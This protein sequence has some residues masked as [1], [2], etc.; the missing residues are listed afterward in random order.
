MAIEGFTVYSSEEAQLYNRYRWWLGLTWGDVLDKVSDLYPRKVGLVDDDGRLTY[1]ELRQKVDCLALGLMDLGIKPTDR[2]LLQVPNWCEYVWAF[3][4][5]QKIGA[6]PILLLPRHRETEINFLSQL[7]QA[8]AW[9]LP[10]KN[11][12]VDYRPIIQN[13]ARETPTIENIITVR[14]ERCSGFL[15]ME[16][17][18]SQRPLTSENLSQLAERRPD[19]MEV[20]QIMP[21]GGTTG[22]PKAVPRTHNSFLCNAEYHSKAWEITSQDTVLT[23]APVSH[24]QGMF[25]GVGGA[26]INYARLVLIDS[27]DPA[28]ICKVIEKE[29]VSAIPT[30]PALVS[31]LVN[32]DGRKNF[33]L[34]SL[35]KVY[36]GGGPSSPDLVMAVREKLGCAFVNVFGS[37][38]GTNSM[39][40]LDDDLEVICNT[41]GV[42]CCPYE[43][44]KIIDQEGIALPP[45]TVG[46][47]VSKGPGIFTGYFGAGDENGD[48]FTPDGFFR[49]GDLARIDEVGNIT[50]TGRMKDIILRGGENISAIE[51]ENLVS[52]HEQIEAVAVIGMPDEELGERI[53]AYVQTRP[54]SEEVT[55]DDIIS[56]LRAK[57]ASVLQLPERIVFVD[58]IPL[59]KV[60]K[61]D[62]KALREDIRKRMGPA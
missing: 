54:G 52:T 13:V 16:D 48:L 62:K 9:I 37:S 21:T 53:C 1:R 11:R 17:L 23:I 8:K 38:E 45:N 42:K 4:A 50:I 19:P 32:F 5:L 43:T 35:K 57:G 49:T 58:G 3:F 51:I 33:D 55:F 25:C 12:N 10:L 56:F 20:A 2:V 34:S 41:V 29:K 46:E 28:D 27:T 15:R 60:G 36:S 39:T 61:V 30:V 31:R 59:T 18:A 47:F 24:A 44:Y 7:T 26:F 6:I 14:E 40:R 22:L